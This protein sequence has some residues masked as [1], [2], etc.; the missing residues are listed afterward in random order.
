MP[1]G[2]MSLND[3]EGGGGKAKAPAPQ[4]TADPAETG[5]ADAAADEG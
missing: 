2:P 4:A 3:E 1:S 5:G